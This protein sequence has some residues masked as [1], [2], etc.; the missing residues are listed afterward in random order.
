[1][2]K[3]LTLF[4]ILYCVQLNAQ[5]EVCHI[6]AIFPAKN[7]KEQTHFIKKNVPSLDLTGIS[8]HLQFEKSSPYSKHYTFDIYYKDLQLFGQYI[9]VNTDMTNKIISISSHL[10]SLQKLATSNIEQQQKNWREPINSLWKHDEAVKKKTLV[11]VEKEF[12][13]ELAQLEQAYNRSI[14]KSKLID[15]NNTLITEWNHL[16]HANIDTFIN[17]EVFSPDP[18]TYLNQNYGAPYV[19]NN[20]NNAAWM[21]AAYIPVNIDATY[22]NITDSFYLENN[23]VKIVDFEAPNI[24]PTVLATPQFNFNRSQSGF[25]ECMILYHIGEFHT[26]ISNLGYNALMNLVVEVD[27]HGQFGGDN[28]V[29]N[30]NGGTPTMS[31]GTGGVDDAEDADVIIHEYSHGISWSAN[32]NGFF[33]AER[34]GL[35]E[36]LGDY[37]CTSYSRHLSSF[38]WEDVFTWDGHNTFWDGRSANVM[39]NYAIPNP[40]NIYDYGN[41]WNTA[42]QLIYTDLGRNTTDALMLETLFYLTDNSTLP[43]AAYYMLQADSLLFN[44]VNVPTICSRFQQK[45]LLTGNCF[46]TTITAISN[47]VNNIKISNTLAFANGSGN[48]FIQLDNEKYDIALYNINGQVITTFEQVSGLFELSPNDLVGGVYILKV[49]SSDGVRSFKLVRN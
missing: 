30:R 17:A 1:M 7:L 11:L 26:H 14:D 43:D 41:I 3:A 39:A 28:S 12:G 44:G 33:S 21:N 34:S 20:D 4:F 31:F 47:T 29:F 42:M 9:K 19:D 25:E 46:P 8:F 16:R 6:Q 13:F 15:K 32:N 27:A 36:G 10:A 18:L 5:D 22:D 37:F 24:A 23:L 48:A 45:N 40:G 49:S 35:D 38:R 2:K